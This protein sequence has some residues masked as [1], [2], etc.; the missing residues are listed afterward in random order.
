MRAELAGAAALGDPEAYARALF[1]LP[2]AQVQMVSD[3]ARGRHHIALVVDGITR[4]ALFIAPEPVALSRDFVARRIG[5][6]APSL[7]AGRPGADMP[8]PGALVCACFDVGVNTITAAIREGRAQSVA[9]IGQ[10]L[11]AGTNCGSCRG[12]IA[13]ILAQERPPASAAE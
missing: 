1:G 6:D 4:A 2:D 13:A 5:S 11:R 9:E 8:D 12:Q 3:P 7:V 10:A